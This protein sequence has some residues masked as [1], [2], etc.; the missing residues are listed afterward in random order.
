[1]INAQLYRVLLER[2]WRHRGPKLWHM[3]AIVGRLTPV[4]VICLHIVSLL[5]C[6]RSGTIAAPGPKAS[7]AEEDGGEDAEAYGETKYGR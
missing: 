7:N 6:W 4:L 1:M 3:A 2:N 5:I